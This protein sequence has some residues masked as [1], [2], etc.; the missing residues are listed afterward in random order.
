M[1]AWMVEV[2]GRMM[3]VWLVVIKADKMADMMADKSAV[4]KVLQTAEH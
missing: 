4:E 3:A 1:A 2:M